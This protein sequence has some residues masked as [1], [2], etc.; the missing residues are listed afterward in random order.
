MLIQ[1]HSTPNA[2]LLRGPSQ[3]PAAQPSP[4]TPKPVEDSVTLGSTP[5][6][7]ATGKPDGPEGPEGPKHSLLYRGARFVVGSV[8]AVVGGAIGAAVGGVV[9]AGD[10]VIPL[11][12]Q[13]V[14]S[15]ILRP[16]LAAAGAVAG[17]FVGVS[18]IPF[19]GPA[20][21]AALG[22][23]AGAVVGGGLP[24]AL[25]ALAA[26]GKG[27]VCGGWKGRKQGYDLLAN[28]FDKVAEKLQKP[29]APPQDPPAPPPAS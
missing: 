3:Q 7:S 15:K 16:G 21:G 17:A 25:D 19:I 14:A 18:I 9:H 27:A 23:V 8:G 22:A 28:A 5:A 11:G 20:K 6:A 2:P 13:K 29:P 4:S 24:G 26:S 12:V 1:T 10:T